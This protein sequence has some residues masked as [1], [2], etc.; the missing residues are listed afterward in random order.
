MVPLDLLDHQV[1]RLGR[2]NGRP[3]KVWQGISADGADLDPNPSLDKDPTEIMF[4]IDLDE[5][6]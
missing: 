4:E 5:G 3:S 1:L 6:F 2:D